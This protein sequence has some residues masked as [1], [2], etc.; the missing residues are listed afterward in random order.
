L[1]DDDDN[2]NMCDGGLFQRYYWFKRSLPVWSTE[3]R[4][5][6]VDMQNMMQDTFDTI[7]P[8]MHF[9]ISLEESNAAVLAL[10]EEYKAKIC[11]WR[12]KY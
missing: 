2:D 8:K 4:P 7:R 3:E 9:C 10:E 5:F 12:K 1:N 11:E 6:P